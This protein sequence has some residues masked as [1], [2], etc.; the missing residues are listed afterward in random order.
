MHRTILCYGDS[1]TWGYIPTACVNSSPQRYP[2][3]Q[4]WTGIL[5]KSLGN[6]YYVIEEGLNSRTT[7]VDHPIPPNRNG[8]TYLLPCLYTHAPIDLVVLALGGNDLKQYF[9]RSV[10]QIAE[11]LSDLIDTI[12]NTTYGQDLKA[13]PQILVI[14]MPK[15]SKSIEN[16]TDDNGIKL[17]EK[18]VQKS[19][20]LTRYYSELSLRKKCHFLDISNIPLSKL[21]ALHLDNDGHIQLS[22]LIEARIKDLYEN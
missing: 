18:A 6:N 15:F 17:F 8:K 5:Q 13:P 20:L 9:N 19:R 16:I 2:R 4:R 1:N 7:N 11:G 14:S 22:K 12:Q 21:D 10:E 3:N